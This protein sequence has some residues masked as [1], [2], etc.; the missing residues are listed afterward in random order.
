MTILI[1]S[2]TFST[3]CQSDLFEIFLTNWSFTIQVLYAVC[4]CFNTV[5]MKRDFL[6]YK[7]GIKLKPHP[8]QYRGESSEVENIT[9]KE[10]YEMQ[11]SRNAD[12]LT[13]TVTLP[14]NGD[15][16]NG[17]INITE[18]FPMKKSDTEPRVTSNNH[19]YDKNF[20]RGT[21]STPTTFEKLI[22]M[23]MNVAHVLPH[24]VA[25]GYWVFVYKYGKVI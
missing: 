1:S 11:L 7:L 25:F 24:I 9:K 15:D 17:H 2:L 12:V 22:W 19:D 8:T 14:V 10:N 16:H 13:V 20:I 3:L 18:D 21:A 5:W 6:S 4:F 23:L